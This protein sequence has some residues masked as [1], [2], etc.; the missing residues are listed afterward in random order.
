MSIKAIR[1]IHY[2]HNLRRQLIAL[3]RETCPDCREDRKRQ[4]IWVK[5]LEQ[6]LYK[7]RKDD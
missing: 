5:L 1:A 7:K 2:R 3:D 6:I 4:R